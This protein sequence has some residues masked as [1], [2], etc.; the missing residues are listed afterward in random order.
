MVML[1]GS[2]IYLYFQGNSI[3]ERSLMNVGYGMIG[4][5]LGSVAFGIMSLLA[6][7]LISLISLCRKKEDKIHHT[8]GAANIEFE[9]AE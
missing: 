3:S 8:Q 4:V 7:S 9:T 6:T 1:F 2:V 5:I